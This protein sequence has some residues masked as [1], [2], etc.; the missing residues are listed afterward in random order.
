MVDLLVEGPP[1]T[2]GGHPTH[3]TSGDVIDRGGFSEQTGRP[4]DAKKNGCPRP[5]VASVYDSAEFGDRGALLWGLFLF[6]F[7]RCRQKRQR[8]FFFFFLHTT[9]DRFGKK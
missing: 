8:F 9:D 3:P 5:I 4:G 1:A 2:G 7:R 6:F